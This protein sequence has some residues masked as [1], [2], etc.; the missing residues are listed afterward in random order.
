MNQNA[1][2]QYPSD[3]NKT[4][5]LIDFLKFHFMLGV[6]WLTT[7]NTQQIQ[8]TKKNKIK[9]HLKHNKHKTLKI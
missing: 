8:D 2:L 6:T 7:L 9:K 5:N 3:K 1:W 4:Q